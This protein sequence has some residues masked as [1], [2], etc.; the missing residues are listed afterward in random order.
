LAQAKVVRPTYAGSQ[1][2]TGSPFGNSTCCD[3]D[4]GAHEEGRDEG[5]WHKPPT[6]NACQC[7]CSATEGSKDAGADGVWECRN[8]GNWPALTPLLVLDQCAETDLEGGE[9]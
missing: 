9:E 7:Q 8:N 4:G 5:R 6:E 1:H 2:G 3:D